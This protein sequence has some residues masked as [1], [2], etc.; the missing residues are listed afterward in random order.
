MRLFRFALVG[1]AIGAAVGVLAFSVGAVGGRAQAQEGKGAEKRA[2]RQEV[3]AQ[4]LGV[5]VQELQTALKET[6]DQLID[7]AL[8]AGRITP[9]QAQKLRDAKPGAVRERIKQR[10]GDGKGLVAGIKDIMGTV[11]TSLKVTPEQ[12]KQE[13]SS[14]KSLA[15]VAADHG[16]SRDQLKA[17]ILNEAKSKL[18]AAASNGT[19]TQETSAKLYN[20]LSQRIDQLLDRTFVKKTN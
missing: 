14:G 5:S 7:E 17:T 12:L 20:A 8:K 13:M 16:V 6:R 19:I 18:N 15:Q 3:L 2:H 9:E 4:Q 1:L 11:A 10:I